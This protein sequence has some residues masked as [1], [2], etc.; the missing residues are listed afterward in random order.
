LAAEG[1]AVAHRVRQF[2]SLV[3]PCADDM[4]FRHRPDPWKCRWSE[5]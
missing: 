5:W 1:V 3:A 2:R 4:R